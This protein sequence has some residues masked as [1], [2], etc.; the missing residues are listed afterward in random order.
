MY[1]TMEEIKEEMN[2]L[3]CLVEDLGRLKSKDF[4]NKSKR[5]E[6]IMDVVP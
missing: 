3:P 5:T 1:P 6:E 4:K 2:L